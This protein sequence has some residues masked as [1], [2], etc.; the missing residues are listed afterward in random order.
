[1][2]NKS[3]ILFGAGRLGREILRRAG[4]SKCSF[5]VDNDFRKSGSLV[6]GIPVVCFEDFLKQYQ[7]ELVVICTR[8]ELANEIELQLLENGIFSY[9][10]YDELQEA[11]FAF[12][13]VMQNPVYGGKFATNAAKRTLQRIEHLSSREKYLKKYINVT[14]LKAPTG[15]LRQRQL[16]IISFVKEIM[17]VFEKLSIK[18]ILFAGN[19][20]GYIRHGGFIP[21][22]DDLDFELIREDYD[23]LI[24]YWKD[25]FITAV[26][27]E[28]GI[29]SMR[30][31]GQQRFE[32]EMTRKNPGK[33]ILFVFPEHIAISKGQNSIDRVAIDF[34]CID[35]YRSGYAFESHYKRIQEFKQAMSLI[36]MDKDKFALIRKMLENDKMEWDQNGPHLYFGYDNAQSSIYLNCLSWI[37]RDWIFPLRRVFYEG[38][39]TYIPNNPD[40]CLSYIFGK[41][42]M[43]LPNDYGMPTHDYAHELKQ[44]WYRTAEIYVTETE[45][46]DLFFDLYTSLRRNDIYTVYVFEESHR[47]YSKRITDDDEVIKKLD[48]KGVEWNE[49]PFPESEMI[50]TSENTRYLKKYSSGKKYLVR[51]EDEAFQFLDGLLEAEKNDL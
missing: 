44:K 42:Y 13:R 36:P 1:M 37:D 7:N 16:K 9:V 49:D 38:V 20:L 19:L 31:W 3:L 14:D 6:E 2:E 17:P 21:W 24:S 25:N 8:G 27:Q 15:Y 32:D 28:D 39:E 41:S 4:A 5:F 11:G 43:N 51:S 34:F 35:S 23:R 18:P 12:D 33:I 47:R 26:S 29:D 22:D 40:R 46:I 30:K 45:D 50:F 48:K 10:L